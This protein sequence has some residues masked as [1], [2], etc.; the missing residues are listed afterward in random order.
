[1]AITRDFINDIRN[2]I[3]TVIEANDDG[4]FG[5]V[6]AFPKSTL[7]GFPAVVIMMAENDVLFA[8]TG[9][10][11][12]R[13]MMLSFNLEVYYPV[14]KESEQEKAE[15]AM[16][17]A[18]SQLIKIFS[19]KKPLT[20]CDLAKVGLS[21]WDEVVVGEATY[22]TARVNLVCSTYVDTN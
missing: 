7:D 16:G 21:P 15:T 5:F 19:I 14:T 1:M 2:E 4:L 9:S 10:N 11:D 18:V 8:S 22:R 17:E 12:S 6:S 13:K 3:K 20:K